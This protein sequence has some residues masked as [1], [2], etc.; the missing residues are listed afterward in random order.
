MTVASNQKMT[1]IGPGARWLDVYMKLDALSLTV[2]G[3]RAA[4]VGVGGL[5][6]GG[7]SMYSHCLG[8]LYSRSS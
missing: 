5:V 2:A 6:T 7:L 1:S 4:T 3:G 8:T